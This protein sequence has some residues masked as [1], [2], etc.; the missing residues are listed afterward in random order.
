MFVV[1]SCES[2]EFHYK[3]STALLLSPSDRI[4]TVVVRQNRLSTPVFI[5]L[6]SQWGTPVNWLQL[7]SLPR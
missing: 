6:A 4:R 2:V 5:S 7:N 3:A 1:V